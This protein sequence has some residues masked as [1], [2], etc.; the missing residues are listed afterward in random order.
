METRLDGNLV[1]LNGVF[2]LLLNFYDRLFLVGRS[3]PFFKFFVV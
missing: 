2:S 1:W 3:I